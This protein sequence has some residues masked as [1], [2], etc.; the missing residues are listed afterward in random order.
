[1]KIC[2]V[3]NLPAKSKIGPDLQV[4]GGAEFQCYLIGKQLAF[5]GWDVAYITQKPV[6]LSDKTF[7][8]YY[9]NTRLR[10]N[11]VIARYSRVL[12]LFALLKEIN[13]DIVVTT[14]MGSLSGFVAF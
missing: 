7:R 11:G 14:Y 13:A 2:F 8:A 4:M 5:R 12:S 1:M 10:G 3:V 9:A 6:M